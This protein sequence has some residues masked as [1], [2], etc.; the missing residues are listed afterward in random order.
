MRGGHDPAWMVMRGVAHPCMV[1]TPDFGLQKIL[2]AGL[3][4]EGNGQCRG[5]SDEK[6]A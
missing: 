4:P 1:E 6:Q 3:D 5:G 2:F